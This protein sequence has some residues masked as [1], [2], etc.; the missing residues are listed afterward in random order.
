MED[1]RAKIGKEEYQKEAAGKYSVHCISNDNGKLL[2]QLATINGFM[3]TSTTVPHKNIQLG[4]WRIPGSNE[5][6]SWHH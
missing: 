6:N 2:G 4:T 3:I 1:F 5:V